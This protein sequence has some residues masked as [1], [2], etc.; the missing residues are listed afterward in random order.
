MSTLTHIAI[1][2]SGGLQ[3]DAYAS[4][5]QVTPEQINAYHKGHFQM[6]S[7]FLPGQWGG[8]NFGYSP[9]TR[10]FH[11]FR[12]IGEE[13]AAQRG[14][15]FNTIS[16]CIFGNYTKRPG[17]GLSVDPMTPEMEKDIAH[18]V[19]DLINGNSRGYVTAPNTKL[20]L[21]MARVFPHRWFQAGTDCYG[22]ALPDSW[23]Q[24]LLA[25]YRYTT[26]D[27]IKD[28]ETRDKLRQTLI[29]LILRLRA[30]LAR[31]EAIK[32]AI[33]GSPFDKG[34]CPEFLLTA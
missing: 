7:K 17:S 30:E 6:E 10:E 22:T 5:R 16:I 26:N 31:R 12:A 13:T 23:I 8:Y 28:V 21:S 20:D 25:K 24:N 3:L 2:N 14:W 33:G 29:A 27:G 9:V 4:T 18:F 34:D 15:N 19:L 11:Q 1:H 32:L